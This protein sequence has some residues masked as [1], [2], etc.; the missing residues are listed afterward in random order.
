MVEPAE[1]SLAVTLAPGGKGDPLT[2]TT[3]VIAASGTFGT[4]VELR[5]VVDLAR[6]GAIV[7]PGIARSTRPARGPAGAS[8]RAVLAEMPAGLLLAERY[9]T[10]GIGRALRGPARSWGSLGAPVIANVPGE[11]E[12]ECLDVAAALVAVEALA[13]LEVDF[14]SSALRGAD[15]AAAAL[16][17]RRLTE[18]LR[19]VWS[20][21]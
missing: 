1:V 21:A 5:G 4:G 2:L 7:T 6:L 11:D 17:V 3:P 12:D 18:R 13:G 15:A 14:T 19:A 16:A 10:L 20:P 8:A 9:A